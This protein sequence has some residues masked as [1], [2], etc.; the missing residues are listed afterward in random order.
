MSEVRFPR[1][2]SGRPKELVDYGHQ[3]RPGYP[4]SVHALRKELRAH[5]KE[6]G[7]SAVIKVITSDVALL[8]DYLDH[9][10]ARRMEAEAV[11]YSLAPTTAVIN[12]TEDI[13]HDEIVSL[14][15]TMG[16]VRNCHFVAQCLRTV[17]ADPD[18]PEARHVEQVA[19]A[20]PVEAP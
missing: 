7:A 9:I 4:G 6:L 12:E 17:P 11:V 8:L 16:R 2:S 15:T 5:I 20:P 14:S 1:R 10:D 19:V 3:W 18:F 13:P